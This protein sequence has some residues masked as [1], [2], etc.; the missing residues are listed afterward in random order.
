[1]VLCDAILDADH[2]ACDRLIGRM[3][4]GRSADMRRD[5]LTDLLIELK[6]CVM[7]HHGREEALMKISGYPAIAA[8]TAE[9]AQHLMALARVTEAVTQGDWATV[10]RLVRTLFE[11]WRQHRREHDHTLRTFIDAQQGQPAA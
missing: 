9:H 7:A 10:D 11:T 3:L 1:M 8:H 6:V 4:E 5:V 2:Q